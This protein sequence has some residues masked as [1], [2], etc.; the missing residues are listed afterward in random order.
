M[1]LHLMLRK[2][3]LVDHCRLWLHLLLFLVFQELDL[4]V[5]QSLDRVQ[6]FYTVKPRPDL[7]VVL[8]IFLGYVLEHL[9]IETQFLEDGL[10]LRQLQAVVKPHENLLVRPITQWLLAWCIYWTDGLVACTR[11]GGR[12]LRGRQQT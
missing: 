2:H 10:I 4:A 5:S 1:M 3:R 9:T 8:Q 7:Q 6:D 11:H 12:L